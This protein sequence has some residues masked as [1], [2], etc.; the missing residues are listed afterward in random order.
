MLSEKEKLGEELKLL[1]ESLELNVITKEEFENAKQRIDAKL[2][3]LEQKKEPEVREKEE[4]KEEIKEEKPEVEGELEVEKEEKKIEIKEVE[5]KKDAVDEKE[6][7]KK[8]VEHEEEES[9]K[10]E[11]QK[12]LGE[13][14]GK[15]EV[16]KEEKPVEEKPRVT[17]VEEEKDSKKIFT[18]IAIIVILG[19]IGLYFFFSESGVDVSGDKALSLVACSSDNDCVR[20]GS[21]GKCNNPG[22][23][24]SECEYIEDIEVK[25]MVL[26]NKNCF[27]CDT[28]RVLSILN[29]FFP[30]VDMENLDFETEEGKEIAEK[31]DITALPAYILNSSLQQAYNYYKFFNAFDKVDSSYVMK[32]TV[33]NANYYIEREEIPNKLDLFVKKDQSASTKAEE[34]LQEFLGA[35]DGKVDFEKHNEDAK[36]VKELGINSFP[37]FLINNKIKFSGVQAADKIKGNFCQM[38]EFDE[39]SLELSK[40]LVR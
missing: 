34:N 28:G 35:F 21:I 25:L 37:A 11:K 9:I 30:T 31:F 23:E 16:E 15:P 19:F 1:K 36:I 8:E 22:K 10:E 7:L 4:I 24:S 14:E 29:G 13:V 26:N 5:L 32:N 12:K 18:Y 20:E 2:N 27:N 33:A 38:N 17:I 6:P 40:S 39:C 3:E